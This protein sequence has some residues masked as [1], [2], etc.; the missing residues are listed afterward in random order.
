MCVELSVRQ[1]PCDTQALRVL[2]W[3]HHPVCNSLLNLCTENGSNSCVRLHEHCTTRAACQVAR[4]SCAV[5][6]AS[7][8][9]GTAPTPNDADVLSSFKKSYV[10]VGWRS[11]RPGLRQCDHLVALICTGTTPRACKCLLLAANMPS[12]R[13]FG[14]RAQQV[15]LGMLGQRVC[16][17][18]RHQ[19][20]AEGV[21]RHSLPWVLFKGT[22]L[23][24]CLV[25][26]SHLLSG[27][28]GN[29][30]CVHLHP[31]PTRKQVCLEGK[32]A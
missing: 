13:I 26:S 21:K 1:E 31:A 10:I 8:L 14:C 2:Q 15:Y 30:R 4:H 19:V 18:V 25:G 32:G 17:V 27:S 22:C 29:E 28:L 5:L 11:H 7:R 3:D 20:V 12:L 16:M 9:H 23:T 6:L 24:I